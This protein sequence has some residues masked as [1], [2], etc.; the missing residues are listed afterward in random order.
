MSE[1]VSTVSLI[2]YFYHS[3]SPHLPSSSETT[4]ETCS[5]PACHCRNCS[6]TH[7]NSLL[8][9]FLYTSFRHLTTSTF[10]NVFKPFKPQ[11]IQK[12]LDMC[13]YIQIFDN[14]QN[15]QNIPGFPAIFSHSFLMMES[16]KFTK[17]HINSTLA[18]LPPRNSIQILKYSTSS[19][20][21]G[22]LSTFQIL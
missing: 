22:Y 14:I 10:F 13:G 4:G 18:V 19:Q 16:S 5:I 15:F 20:H 17:N 11:K 7:K 1:L 9:I 8:F 12:I 2:S 21:S 6:S 3:F